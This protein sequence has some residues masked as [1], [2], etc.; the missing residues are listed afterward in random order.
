MAYEIYIGASKDPT[1]GALWYHADYVSPKWQKA[2]HPVRKIGQHI[3]YLRD[4]DDHRKIRPTSVAL[5][6]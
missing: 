5:D 2:F 1:H 3:F 4:S 6:G